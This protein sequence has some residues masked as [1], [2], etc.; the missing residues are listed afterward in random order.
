MNE[1]NAKFEHYLWENHLS[2]ETNRSLPSSRLKVSLCNDEESSSSLEFDFVIDTALTD[3]EKVIDAP[4]T[5]LSLVGSSSLS[6]PKDIA[7][8]MLTLLISSLPLV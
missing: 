3:L 6:T 7:E 5:P 8:G 1:Q 2:H 4:L